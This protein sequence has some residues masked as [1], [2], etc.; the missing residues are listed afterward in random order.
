MARSLLI[1]LA[2]VLAVLL[3]ANS[4]MAAIKNDRPSGL[5]RVSFFNFLVNVLLMHIIVV[6]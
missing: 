1:A 2:A 3:F 5:Q 4:G 6:T